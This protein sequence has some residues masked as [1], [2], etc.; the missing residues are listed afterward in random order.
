MFESENEFYILGI[1]HFSVWTVDTMTQGNLPIEGDILCA[2]IAPS[3]LLL[4]F[5]DGYVLKY[6]KGKLELSQRIHGS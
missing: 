3:A 6:I 1:D 2:D 5:K 4:G